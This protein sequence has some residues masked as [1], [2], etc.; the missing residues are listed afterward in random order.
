MGPLQSPCDSKHCRYHTNRT[1]R[2]FLDMGPNKTLQDVGRCLAVG[3]AQVQVYETLPQ[4]HAGARP[5]MLAYWEGLA[6]SCF[7]HPQNC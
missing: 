7:Q 6:S 5:A 3:V 4:C 1:I 2:L